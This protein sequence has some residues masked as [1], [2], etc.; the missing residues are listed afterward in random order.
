VIKPAEA[1]SGTPNEPGRLRSC[2]RRYK[3]AHATGHACRASSGT[4]A[5]ITSVLL[6]ERPR[7][8]ARRRRSPAGIFAADKHCGCCKVAP[9]WRVISA[10][11][12]HAVLL[13]GNAFTPS[14]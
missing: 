6:P 5:V 9:P 13:C 3:P 4:S 2:S 12:D 11:N 14:P 1:G 7:A 8:A 10:R